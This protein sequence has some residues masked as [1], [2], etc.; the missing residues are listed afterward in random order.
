[1]NSYFIPYTK[2]NSKCIT[3]LINIVAKTIKSLEENIEK[4]LCEPGVD[5]DFLEHKIHE[6]YI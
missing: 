2:I 3:G 6:S 5:K 4:N 1:M